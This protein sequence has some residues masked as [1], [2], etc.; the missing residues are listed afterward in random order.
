[1]SG[2]QLN[3]NSKTGNMDLFQFAV[4][5]P[6]IALLAFLRLGEK[7]A[8]QPQKIENSQMDLLNR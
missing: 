7:M 2:F 4:L 1:M 3:E 5:N 6:Q 8:S